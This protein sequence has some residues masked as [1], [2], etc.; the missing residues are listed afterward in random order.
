MNA[1]MNRLD[2]VA[3]P[4]GSAPVELVSIADRMVE[5]LLTIHHGVS[6]GYFELIADC[7]PMTA[8]D[9]AQLTGLSVSRAQ[10]WLDTQ[11]TLGV[12]KIDRLDV[13]RWE[14]R[15]QLPA[16]KA[17]LLLDLEDPFQA[18]YDDAA[19]AA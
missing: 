11:V 1:V 7:G 12:L 9:L 13:P 2:N 8:G 16:A 4:A 5:R 14:R 19:I 17:T 6:R 18:D 10:T 15:Y 3:I